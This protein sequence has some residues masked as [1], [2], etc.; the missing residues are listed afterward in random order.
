MKGTL[1]IINEGII[2][3]TNDLNEGMILFSIPLKK[4][5][6][7]LTKQEIEY[8][9]NINLSKDIVGIIASTFEKGL[10]LCIKEDN[11]IVPIDLY[12]GSRFTIAEFID[13]IDN[14]S[15]YLYTIQNNKVII[16]TNSL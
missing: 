10:E 7:P 14:K 2:F 15:E 5:G 4:V 9:K 11:Q 8:I 3:T 16:E 1:R 12:Q 13:K 6:N